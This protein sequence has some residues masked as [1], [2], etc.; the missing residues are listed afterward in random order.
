MIGLASPEPAKAGQ[1]KGG[2]LN[3]SMN[4]RPVVDPR[5]FDWSAMG[6]VAR[7]FVEPLVRYTKD[8]TFE[9]WL[10]ESWEI[11]DDAKNYILHVRQGVSWSNGRSFNVDDVIYNIQRWCDKSVPGNSMASRMSALINPE[12][13]QIAPG[14]LQRIDDY[15]LAIKLAH[16][17][18]S[19]IAGMAD[20][21][22]LIVQRGFD[23]AGGN[24]SENPIG[25]GPF[26]LVSLEVG[27]GAEVRRRQN[28]AWWGGHV[29]LDGIKWIDFGSDAKAE[30]DAFK[31]GKIH[32]NY[33][34][35]ISRISILDDM[36]MTK[37]EAVTA[38]TVVV[39]T[40][41]N[42]PPYDDKRVRNALQLAV[43]NEFVLQNAYGGA[44]TVAENHHVCPIHP[45]Y[46]SL[47]KLTK[48]IDA[49][50]ELLA[51]AGMLDFEHEL[52]SIDG[53]YRSDT[54]DAVAAELR[55]AGIK[56]KRTNLPATTFWDHWTKYPYSVT[57]WNM[58]PL[59]VQV[60]ALVYR[61]GEAWNET[62]FA[63]PDF[64]SKL[65]QALTIASAAKRQKLMAD[66]QLILQ[67]EGVIIQPYWQAIY[68]H[69]APAVKNDGMHPTFEMHFEN[70]W[71]DPE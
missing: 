14:T 63:N 49:S 1:I 59:G 36:G 35:P 40:N 67:D 52:I 28:G 53:D 27:V 10:L 5:T 17:D 26:E 47:P 42:K 3:V 69:M 58:R 23:E 66:I 37:A 19:I 2:I 65:N 31:A 15:T 25:T 48:N 60:L 45:E 4:V 21:P 56:V 30:L 38:S 62:G 61:S 34:T 9:P 18:I 11:D 13:G 71:L 50:R 20:Y 41:V 51:S 8:F 55:Q 68:K 57:N 29:S 33:Q 12:T 7:Q 54:A 6:N 43:S 32:V 22:A 39:R 46:A 44:G 24:L 16:A 64:D 70:V